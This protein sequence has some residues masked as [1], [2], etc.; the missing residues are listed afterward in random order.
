MLPTGTIL[1]GKYRVERVLG[2]GG[3]GVVVQATHLQLHQSVAMKFLLPEVLTNPEVVQRF[4]REAQAVV[5]L[6][7][8]HVA[9]VIDVGSLDDGAP[10]MVLEYLE[11]TDLA[12]FPRQQLT[13][14][15]IVDLM[16][17]AC[18]ALAEA[19]AI[20]IVHRDLKPANFFITQR[21]DGSRLLKVLDFGISKLQQTALERNL[22]ATATVMGTPAY[23]SPEQMR[24]TRDV[25]NR[26]DIWALG[27]VLYELLQGS[28][29]FV[30]ETFGAMVIR[31]ATEPTPPLS[32]HL[33]K[34]LAE[35]VARCLEKDPAHRF[36]NVAE[37]AHE[38]APYA[39]STAQAVVSVERT[40]RVLRTD[41]PRSPSMLRPSSTLR[42]SVGAITQ[43][44]QPP[45][46]ARRL[47]YVV[48]AVVAFGAIV[49]I[50]LIVSRTGDGYDGPD[51]L[52]SATASPS[53]HPPSLSPPGS[54]P[55]PASMPPDAGVA[56]APPDA[57][58]A[59]MPLPAPDAA[60][61]ASSAAVPRAVVHPK[62]PASTSS[63]GPRP[64]PLTGQK[65]APSD[66]DPSDILGPRA[67]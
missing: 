1:A 14:G 23:M 27:V 59:H 61:A 44:P 67:P 13:I 58:A 2:Q 12:D 16:L 46:S 22:T 60:I 40:S 42:S 51:P 28:P 62:Q 56:P 30:G 25:D 49:A 36:Q 20:G 52:P 24:S 9:R 55:A 4:L 39:Q 53:A 7:S 19:H 50:A 54:E 64:G 38:L 34:K 3:M 63:R 48:G 18:E 45:R 31:V 32:A 5:R 6:K 29:P 65:P 66:G 47:P 33:P 41:P 37:L 15:Q 10:Y 43:L 26:S 8:E 17:Q 11:G 21:S 57:A 35:V